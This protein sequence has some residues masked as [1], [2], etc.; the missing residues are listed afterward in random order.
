MSVFRKAWRKLL[1][2][3]DDWFVYAVT[4]A[5]I[6]FSSQMDVLK[7]GGDISLDISYGRFFLSSIV[8]LGIIAYQES[9]VKDEGGSTAKSR[10]GRKKHFWERVGKGIAFGISWP[11]VLEFFLK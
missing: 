10:A 2:W 6:M 8:C 3:A 4:L 7:A 5:S 1:S 11:Q 9:L